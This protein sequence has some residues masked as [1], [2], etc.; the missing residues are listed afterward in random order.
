MSEIQEAATLREK[1]QRLED[2]INQLPQVDI[3]TRHLFAP[4]L[5]AR[6]MFVPAGTVITGAVHKTE[7]IAILS[8][9]RMQLATE[10]GPIEI[11]A[12]WIGIVKP[13]AKNAGYAIEDCVWTNIMHNPTD[14]RE[15]EKLVEMFTES[16]H[17]ELIGGK[18]N[19]Q[20]LTAG[21]AEKLEH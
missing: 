21:Q 15:D 11:A 18:E 14:E 19:K 7:N 8:K 20:L 13:G 10:N 5:F 9:G 2:A 4:G 17:S 16:K 6:E 3:P 12:P 1:V